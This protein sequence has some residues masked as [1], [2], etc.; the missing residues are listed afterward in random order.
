DAVVDPSTGAIVCHSTLHHN[1]NN[2]CI[3][4]NIFGEGAA[5]PE[6]IAWV[7]G[8][9]DYDQ[10]N[11]QQVLALTLNRTL[12]SNWAGDVGLATG[13]EYRNEE[14][15]QEVDPL[16]SQSILAEDV[17]HIRGMPV[18]LIGQLGLYQQTN[19]QNLAG[20]ISVKEAFA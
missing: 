1:P 6:S 9:T 7:Q 8:T 17:A 10:N 19:P 14:I 3:P 11:T 4:M 5:S 16:S 20:E 2:G 12:F 18:P 13:L 15:S